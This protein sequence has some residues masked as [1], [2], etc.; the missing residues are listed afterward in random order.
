MFKVFVYGTLKPG[1]SNYQSYCAGKILNSQPA[2]TLGYLYDLPFG[3]P[4]MTQ[5]DQKVKGF[6][7]TFADNHHLEDLDRL[8]GYHLTQTADSHGYIRQLVAI[9]QLDGAYLD[10]AWAYFMTQEQ[11]KRFGGKFLASGCWQGDK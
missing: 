4:A 8:E 11:I 6:L 3:Y 2:Y 5:G 1:K 10:H 9:Y 7:M